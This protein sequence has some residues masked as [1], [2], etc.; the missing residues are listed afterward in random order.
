M[1][2]LQSE[3]VKLPIIYFVESMEDLIKLPLGIPFIRGKSHEFNKCLMALEFDYLY[4]AALATGLPFKWKEVLK[5]AGFDKVGKWS[6]ASSSYVDMASG[7]IKDLSDLDDIFIKHG[8]DSEQFMYDVGYK[9]EIDVLQDLKLIPKW[10]DDIEKTVTIN[11]TESML[12]NPSLYSKKHDEVLGGL[13]FAPMQKNVLIIDISSS[14]P[15]GVSSTV[16]ALAKT[17]AER[18]YCDLVITGSRSTLYPYEEVGELD[19]K[20]LYDYNG[21][22]NDQVYFR[23]LVEDPKKYKTAIVFGDN[24]NPGYAW[25]NKY[26]NCSTPISIDDGKKLCKWEIDEIIS[27]HTTESSKLAG[28][29]EWF[30]CPNIQYIAGWV[31]DLR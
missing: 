18:F 22:D 26:N 30:D 28:Y 25:C 4:K 7:D 12:F 19:I 31:K 1:R 10:Y 23:K 17:L 15:R 5:E 14:I 29:A 20:E 6:V 21:M 27:F 8:I 9:V 13:E 11:I 24:H 16:L 2:L 3:K